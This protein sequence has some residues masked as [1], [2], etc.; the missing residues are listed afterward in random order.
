MIIHFLAVNCGNQ[1][2]LYTCIHIY[3]CQMEVRRNANVTY[4]SPEGVKFLAPNVADGRVTPSDTRYSLKN[5]SF[6]WCRNCGWAL[7]SSTNVFSCAI[8]SSLNGQLIL[9]ELPVQTEWHENYQSWN[10]NAAVVVASRLVAKSTEKISQNK[11]KMVHSLY[12]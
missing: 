10:R 9:Y 4:E 7:H 11:Y 12:E 1:L 2:L 8:C 6:G 5:A 3:L